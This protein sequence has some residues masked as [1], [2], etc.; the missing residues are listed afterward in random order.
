MKRNALLALPLLG[1]A[2]LA[3]R[4]LPP[5]SDVEFTVPE[6]FAVQE[7]Y[8]PEQAGTVVSITFDGEGRLV[9][10]RENG[11]IV[12]LIDNDGDGV[13]DAERAFTDSSTVLASQGLVFDGP[14]L[15]VAGRS[16]EGTGLFRVP[17]ANGDGVG[18]AAELI[19]L[20]TGAIQEHGPHAVF[21][22]PDGYVYWTQGNFSFIYGR[23]SPLS[24]VRGW[25]N[26]S[27]LGRDDAR[28]FGSAY[29]GG[30]GGNFMRRDLARHSRPTPQAGQGGGGGGRGPGGQS[31]RRDDWELVAM[32]FRNQYDGAFNLMGELFTFDSDME[33]HRDAPWYRPTRTI[34][35]VPGGDYGYREGSH[36]HPEYYFDNLPGVE[37]QGRGSPTGT[38]VYN[39]YNY[40]AD[41]WD[42]LL[43]ADWS[44]GRI[45]AS[46]LTKDGAS[47]SSESFNFVYGEPLNVTD[48]EVGPDGNVYFA[49]G[50]RNTSGGLY[51]VVYQGDD[52]MDR[53]AA[54]AP[55]DRVL[56]LAQP[57]SAFSRQTAREIRDEM[58]MAAWQQGLTA[59]VRNGSATADRRVRAM[60]LL[61]VFGPGMDE[62][63]L[64][65]LVS[66]PAWEVRAAAAY[67]LGM[68]STPSARRELVTLLKDSDPFVQRRAAEA[69]LRTGVHPLVGAP[70]DAEADVLPLL[71]SSDRFVRYAGRLLLQAID[72]NEWTE[73]AFALEQHPQ[74]TEALLAQVE[75]LDEANVWYLTRLARRELELLQRN[76]SGQELLDLVRLIQRTTLK[77]HGVRNFSAA[78]SAPGVGALPPAGAAPAATGGGGRGQGGPGSVQVQIGRLLLD[79]FPAPDSAVNRE[80]A[81]LLAYWGTPGTVE[82]LT[83]ELDNAANSREQQI[84]YAEM[85][86]AVDEGWD[87]PAIDRM[88]TW[89]EKVY[90]EDWRGG[91]SFAGAINR[92]RDDFLG[93]VPPANRDALAARFEAAVPRVAAAPTQGGFGNVSIA[94]EELFEE[95]VYN[96]NIREGDPAGGVVAYERALCGTCHT[97]GPIGREFGPDLTTVNQR[98]SRRDLVRAVV[99]PHETVSD[100]WQVEE[101]T[102]NNGQ[103]VTGSIY[104]EDASSLVVQIPGSTQQVTIA[105]AD[106]RSRQRSERSPMPEGLL[107]YLNG[108]QRRNLFLLLEAGP[109]AIPD[110][111]LTRMGVSR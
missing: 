24:P 27:L 60:E 9:V 98:F 5:G 7:V 53:P 36:V 54:E 74:A 51:R 88:A 59:E 58:G 93:Y 79:R 61:Q 35:A 16:R 34:H 22:G 109:G 45:V 15:L 77:D 107:N 108:A 55:L 43:Q 6:G 68:R 71:A 14:D 87:Q 63:T 85:L 78:A 110:S 64:V 40:P 62:N 105:K 72:P 26:A 39:S 31:A 48:V 75:I 21:F 23:P 33:W 49:L 66:D 28:G 84:H 83:A 44:R 46:R 65:P 111:A 80:I 2:V 3:F 90:R 1:A 102:R 69:L 41:Y 4:Q 57:R 82:K 11:P 96:P 95:L 47:Y 19:E 73:A 97:F 103:V 81:R 18:D 29:T 32:G 50:G 70:I 13:I 12:T 101:I 30:P 94:E 67:Y 25:E 10:A 86:S 99:F 100:L 106:I 92:I 89:L 104:R 42:M 38:I 20:S 8:S 76:P 56:T 91:A 52:A 37:G 17:D